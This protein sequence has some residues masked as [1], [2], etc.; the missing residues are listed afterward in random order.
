MKVRMTS[1]LQLLHDES[2]VQGFRLAISLAE[3]SSS[4][5]S[6]FS[7]R[8]TSCPRTKVSFLHFS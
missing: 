3:L 4:A 6:R 5:D 1:G 8:M 2:L 7:L